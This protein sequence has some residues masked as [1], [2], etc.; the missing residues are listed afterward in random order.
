[1]FY[2]ILANLGKTALFY[3]EH[4]RFTITKNKQYVHEYSHT[5]NECNNLFKE[6]LPITLVKWYLILFS[7]RSHKP[8][9][10]GARGGLKLYVI[11][12]FHKIV[13]KAS[14]PN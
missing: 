5:N 10:C 2:F 11:L 13:F 7:A 14:M 3:T 6:C 1:M 9:R 12:F 8:P 4:R